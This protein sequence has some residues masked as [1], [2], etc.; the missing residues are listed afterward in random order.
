MNYLPTRLLVFIAMS[1]T[2]AVLKLAISVGGGLNA[3]GRTRAADIERYHLAGN[4]IESYD[5]C[6]TALAR[7]QGAVPAGTY[8]GCLV[9]GGAT[10]MHE[11]PK[12]ALQSLLVANYTAGPAPASVKDTTVLRVANRIEVAGSTCRYPH[13]DTQN[14]RSSYYRTSN[15]DA[16][17][18]LEEWQEM[19]RD[20]IEQSRRRELPLVSR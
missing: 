8:C 10:D 19:Q 5:A 7:A 15:D 1:V 12:Q 11:V 14:D 16:V 4:E 2:F 17:R 6:R 20:L 3:P 9:V 13:R 18:S